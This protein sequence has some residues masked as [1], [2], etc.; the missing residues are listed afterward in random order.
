MHSSRWSEL[1]VGRQDLVKMVVVQS[2]IAIVTTLWSSSH[3][4]AVMFILLMLRSGLKSL[5]L[6]STPR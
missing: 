3:L 1:K 6:P 5:S 2:V 4:S